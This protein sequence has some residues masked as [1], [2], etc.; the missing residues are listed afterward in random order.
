MTLRS[1]PFV[2]EGL[3]KCSLIKARAGSTRSPTGVPLCD[4]NAADFRRNGVRCDPISLAGLLL[5]ALRPAREKA[6]RAV[7]LSN[8]QQF[9][10]ALALSWLAGIGTDDV[11]P[12][13]V[14]R[15]GRYRSFRGQGEAAKRFTEAA[16]A[17][18]LRSAI[19]LMG[20]MQNQDAAANDSQTPEVDLSLLEDSL[21]LTPWQRLLENERALALVRMLEAARLPADGPTQSNS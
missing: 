13:P 16:R 12:A 19:S 15:G 11:Q 7:C 2:A 21:R 6:Q 20:S 4:W 3:P 18:M 1:G 8:L 14:V 17:D 9:G 5:P 10:I